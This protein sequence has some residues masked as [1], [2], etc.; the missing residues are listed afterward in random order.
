MAYPEYSRQIEVNKIRRGRVIHSSPSLRVV[1]AVNGEIQNN[2]LPWLLIVPYIHDKPLARPIRG[3]HGGLAT[4]ERF[5]EVLDRQLGRLFNM[6]VV[7]YKPLPKNFSKLNFDV[8]IQIARDLYAFLTNIE[9]TVDEFYPEAKGLIPKIHTAGESM[10]A[11]LLSSLYTSDTIT[12][13]NNGNEVFQDPFEHVESLHMFNIP[14]TGDLPLKY[15]L[16]TEILAFLY[17]RNGK[18]NVFAQALGDL[19]ST[20]AIATGDRYLG[21]LDPITQE[22]ILFYQRKI[23]EILTVNEITKNDLIYNRVK[24]NNGIQTIKEKVPAA[25]LYYQKGDRHYKDE[26]PTQLMSLYEP[27]IKSGLVHLIEIFGSPDPHFSMIGLKG[28]KNSSNPLRDHVLRY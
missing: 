27:L 16:P 20:L 6:W 17:P 25:Y 9:Q 11:V 28:Q 2:N 7:Q 12:H 14:Y 5:N 23:L 15:R 22:M 21:S 24:L 10:G 26:V 13:L 19:I 8:E 1:E 18:A 4:V 3:N